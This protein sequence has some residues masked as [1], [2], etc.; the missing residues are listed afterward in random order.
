MKSCQPGPSSRSSPSTQSPARRP[1]F[2]G[3]NPAWSSA[4]ASLADS[5]LLTGY[6]R[7][8]TVAG[9]FSPA[10]MPGNRAEPVR[11]RRSGTDGDWVGV[12]ATHGGAGDVLEAAVR[13]RRGQEHQR[14]H[15]RCP[16]TPK[17]RLAGQ[18]RPQP[19]RLPVGKDQRVFEWHSG[20]VGELRPPAL[21]VTGQLA[22]PRLDLDQ[23]AAAGCDGQ[24]VDLVDRTVLSDE[25]DVGPGSVRL[26]GGKACSDERECLALMGPSRCP[27][28]HSRDST[29]SRP[30]RPSRSRLMPWPATAAGWRPGNAEI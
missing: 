17:R 11:R 16:L 19:L 25:L 8:P 20:P 3:R 22:R 13:L 18:E 12:T 24:Q 7:S 4:S 29:R 15:P 6:P 14:D 27:S 1:R 21:A 28:V 5:G 26:V 9:S 30:H 23:K 10:T 2:H